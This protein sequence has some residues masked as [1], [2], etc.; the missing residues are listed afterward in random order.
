M[1]R[2]GYQFG[3]LLIGLDNFRSSTARTATTRGRQ[4]GTCSTSRARC[5]T[6][7]CRRHPRPLRRRRVRRHPAETNL[8]AVALVAERVRSAI[9]GMRQAGRRPAPT[10]PAR[11][12]SLSS[13]TMPRRQDLFLFAD[14]MMY[15]AR[16][17][18]RRAWRFPPPTTSSGL[19]RHH[20]KGALVLDAIETA[21]HSLL[22]AHPRRGHQSRRLRGPLSRIEVGGEIITRQEFVEIAEDGR[23]PSPRRSSSTRWV[24]WK[25]SATTATSSSTS[26]RAL[27]LNE[28]A[29]MSARSS[30]TAASRAAHRIRDHRARHGEEPRCSNVSL[31][32]LKLEASKLAI[33][34]FGSG[35][36]SFHYRAAS[37]SA[38]SRSGRFHPNMLTSPKDRAV[39]TNIKS[40]AQEMGITIVARYVE[41]QEVLDDEAARH[42]RASH[43]PG[44]LRRQKPARH[45]IDTDWTPLPR[46]IRPG[47]PRPCSRPAPAA[48]ACGKRDRRARRNRF[49]LEF[50]AH[51]P[52]EQSGVAELEQGV[53][54]MPLVALVAVVAAVAGVALPRQAD[55]PGPR[56]TLRRRRRLR[57]RRCRAPRVRWFPGAGALL[58]SAARRQGR[59]RPVP[60]GDG[61]AAAAR[62]PEAARAG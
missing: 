39:V 30:A 8:G 34:D 54:T 9:A 26:P 12:A 31:S 24:S 60:T 32:E 7:A 37:R 17:A 23:H 46:L 18:V 53:G 47:F 51:K 3:L 48:P 28:F 1:Q 36:S 44:L 20:R 15:K 19:P 45:V 56:R 58:Q 4:N 33:D 25:G 52:G 35:F 50:H 38:S 43:R 49:R 22:P 5:R 59:C 62:H 14:N 29:K 61:S 57:G 16:P 10:T 40:L 11:S 2:H 27:V 42:G 6:P 21:D 55:T 41:S 13:P